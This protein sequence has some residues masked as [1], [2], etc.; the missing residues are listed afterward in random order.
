MTISTTDSRISYN[1]NGV[2]TAFSFP[3]RFLA[4]G[5][6]VV[7]SVSSTGV[8]T[9]KTLTTDY[10]LTGAGDDAG[11]TVTMIAAP[12]S[13]T[14]LIIYRDT[15]IVQ[16]TDYISGDPFPAETH[17]RALDRLT[18]IAQ[19]I[20]SDA[21]RSIK[22]P[23]GDSSS[24]STVLPAA[25]NRLDKFI[26]FDATTGETEL[27]TVTQTQVASAVAAAY[28]AGATADAVTFLQA[29]TGAA[30]RTVQAKLREV[31]L[32]V[33]DFGAVLDG[34]T[35]DYTAVD[36]AI[37]ALPST[38]GRI[39]LP[40]I[41]AIGTK[42]TINR[43]V[44]WVCDGLDGHHDVGSITPRSGFKWIGAAAG[45]M[46]EMVPTTGASAQALT[47]CGVQGG[48]MLDGNSLAAHG[49]KLTSHRFGQFDLIA[50]KG[51]P[52]A[53]DCMTLGVT[54]PLGEATDCQHNTFG[55]LV[56]SQYATTARSLVLT[57]D[58]VGNASFNRFG[59]IAIA[60]TDG[61]AIALLNADNNLFHSVQ[62][63]R[64]GAG[65]GDGVVFGAGASSAVTARNNHFLNLSTNAGVVS[66]GT[67][68]GVVAALDNTIWMYDKGNASPDPTIETGSRL[69][70]SSDLG[71]AS[72]M[73][74]VGVAIGETPAV[75]AA[76]RALMAGESM[77]IR[78]NSGNHMRLSDAT[79]TW[80]VR[81]NGGNLEVSRVSGSGSMVLAAPTL[82]GMTL[83]TGATIGAN[84]A[85]PAQVAQYLT[86]VVN[87]GNYKIPMYNI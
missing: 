64:S 3:Y 71:I 81:V 62:I 39:R 52:D 86:V 47:G 20:G 21:D 49:F 57:G 56:F 51:F 45:T 48:L 27:S 26:V 76:A 8:E 70:W 29:G 18:M 82:S 54:T 13:G 61:D 46:M 75:V 40:G 32:S 72:N 85:P 77:H 1:G 74:L 15:D 42:L 31:E 10:T 17:E 73:G 9:T 6:L 69:M 55:V 63:V 22:V 84:G 34:T 53:A 23:V 2:T 68:S 58:T 67:P 38:G 14:R 80:T 41:A 11:G 35:D 44:V 19:E 37:T 28:A 4:N 78:S 66:Q 5:D 30:A 50:F 79:A 60:H 25:A 12:A 16:E 36:A 7:V 24:L 83:A 65:T 33:T 59:N 87:G 43:R